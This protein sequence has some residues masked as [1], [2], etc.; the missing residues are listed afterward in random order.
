MSQVE[1]YDIKGAKVGKAKLPD[2][3]F[4]V[5]TNANLLRQAAIAQLANSRQS[6]AHTKTRG[7]VSGG[8]RKP[9]RQKGTGKARAG[10]S[11]SPIWVGGGITF[12]PRSDRNYTQSLTKKM[13]RLALFMALADKSQSEH[14]II[15]KDLTLD[16]PKTRVMNEIL[17]NLPTKDGSVL[18]VM[19]ESEPTIEVASANL[20]QVKTIHLSSLN[21]LDILQHDYLLLT[22]KCLQALE[23]HFIKTDEAPAKPEK[24]AKV[25][26]EA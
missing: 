5:K 13:R 21:L 16:K 9:W 25:K 7:E 17:G 24:P 8:G 26:K 10:S 1:I 2:A 15:I 20:P 6:T 4:A 22:Q 18:I 12:G 3:I 11:R 23:N 14:L 19:E